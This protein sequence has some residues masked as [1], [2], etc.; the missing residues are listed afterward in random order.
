MRIR[1]KDFELPT[2]VVL[3]DKTATS[4]YGLFTVEPFE[5]GMGTTIGNS[6]RRVL[7]SSI[8]GTAVTSLKIKGASHEF[9]TIKGVLED[10][11]DITLNL[12]HLLVKLNGESEQKLTLKANKKGIVKAGQ[13]E[14]PMGTE[15]VNPDMLICT[16]TDDVD[17]NAEIEVKRGRRYVT[18]E[19]HTKEIGEVGLIHV[20]SSFSPVT[21][22]KC[23]VENIRVGKLTNYDR[24]IVEIWTNGTISPDM[25]LVE[26]SKILRKHL[27]PFVMYYELGRELQVNERKEEDAKQKEKFREET[28]QKLSM[29]LSELD[30]SVRSANCLSGERIETIGDLV[31]KNEGELL[32]IRNFGKTSLREIKKKLADFGLHLGMD[33]GEILEKKK[34]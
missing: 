23:K 6:L 15:V 18:V 25:A 22:V 32:K 31:A 3:D 4:T 7:Y 26:A 27:N 19:E 17:F 16:L 8:E 30:L 20:D 29:A 9:A 28:I 13:I 10:V 34:E 24:L 21:R 12:K 11:T 1:W 14:M 5:Q 2:R 33:L